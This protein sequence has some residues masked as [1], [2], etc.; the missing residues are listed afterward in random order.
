MITHCSEIFSVEY[1]L[2]G[3]A[4]VTGDLLGLNARNSVAPWSD[5][6]YPVSTENLSDLSGLDF[7]TQSVT[8]HSSLCR[9][10]PA[11]RQSANRT[12]II[13][14]FEWRRDAV[15]MQGNSDR[16]CSSINGTMSE[17]ASE[18]N[19]TERQGDENRKEVVSE[20]TDADDRNEIAA[21][22]PVSEDR[23][24]VAD[25][26][27]AEVRKEV[28]AERPIAARRTAVRSSSFDSRLSATSN[29]GLPVPPPKPNRQRL[30]K[31]MAVLQSQVDELT[32]QL[33]SAVSERDAAVARATELEAELNKYREKFGCVD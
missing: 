10:K 6:S 7:G 18:E 28:V 20:P 17:S 25:R 32:A 33:T 15:L 13:D 4:I 22:C 30:A 9:P 27:I 16:D 14:S 31:N 19:L 11:V 26:P 2:T 8:R 23:K 21:E 29:S 5:S 12:G 1:T 3:A 24:I